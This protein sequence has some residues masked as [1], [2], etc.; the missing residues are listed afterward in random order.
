MTS[1]KQLHA[2]AQQIIAEHDVDTIEVA[3]ADTQG[4]LR[5]KRIPATFFLERTGEKGF[6]QADASFYWSWHCELP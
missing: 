4:H 5:G 2:H 3:F 1:T 6:A